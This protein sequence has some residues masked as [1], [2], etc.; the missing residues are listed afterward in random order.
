MIGAFRFSY[1]S[2]VPTSSCSFSGPLLYRSPV[3][4]FDRGHLCFR[5]FNSTIPVDVIRVKSYVNSFLDPTCVP[6]RILISK[7]DL[8]PD[9]IVAG[10]V[11]VFR[12]GGGLGTGKLYILVVFFDP[13]LHRSPCFSDVDFA[14]L[15]GIPVDNNGTMEQ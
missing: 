4:F 13:L 6:V 12:N 9:R 8:I 11:G 3:V 5:N 1:C 7:L 10:L 14:A 2:I 15:T